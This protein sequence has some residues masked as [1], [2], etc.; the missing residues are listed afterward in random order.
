MK[1]IR[2]LLGLLAIYTLMSCEKDDQVKMPEFDN[3]VAP[4]LEKLLPANLVINETTDLNA[5]L[6]YV[7]WE[8]A[9]YGYAAAASYT[10]QADISGGTFE[11]PLELVTSSTDRAVITAKMLNSAAMGF[12]TESVPVTLDMRLKVVVTSDG[13]VGAPIPAL[14]SNIQSITFTPYIPELPTKDVLY[15]TGKLISGV[16]E[17]NN[18][19]DAVGTG[20]QVCFADDSKADNKIYTYT[21]LM[22]KQDGDGLFKMPTKAGDWN[23][24]YA[25]G[26]DKLSP[27][28]VGGNIPG[29]AS[30][31]YYTM[32]VDLNALTVE[33]APFA[34]GESA[35]RFGTIGIIGNATPSGWDSDTDLTEVAPHVWVLNGI[36]LTA[37][38]VKFRAD[39]GWVDDWGAGSDPQLPFSKGASKGGNIAIEKPGTYFIQFNDLTGHYI[40]MLKEKLL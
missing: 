5:E 35:K 28:N 40:I 12:V 7:I 34:G 17:W 9:D 2:I 24:A 18:S 30:E 39:N 33:F 10:L 25:W 22:N 37:G 36:E 32:T 4:T 11:K 23:D 29:P 21:G 20:L 1:N 13:T 3:L 31:G 14:Y 15:I 27:K 26:G 16:P 19:V 38:E 8:K 6:G